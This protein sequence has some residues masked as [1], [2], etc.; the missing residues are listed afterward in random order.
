MDGSL[1]GCTL[2]IVD[3]F[4]ERPLAGNPLAVVTVSTMP[5]A[6]LRQAFARETNLSETTF[7]AT[8]PDASGHWPVKIHTPDYELPFAGHPTLGTAWVVRERLA[9]AAGNRAAAADA[10]ADADGEHTEVVL[11]LGVGPVRVRFDGAGAGALGWLDAPPVT[12][13]AAPAANDIAALLGVDPAV[14]DAALLPAALADTG[15]R[16]LITGL[17]SRDELAQLRPDAGA[18]SAFLR[19]RSGTGIL[20]V[21]S[22]AP[23]EGDFAARMFFDAGGVREDPAT[24][25][26][27]CC[28]AMVLR[29]MGRRG[30]VVLT[31][32]VEMQRPSRIRMQID[33]AAT[34]IGG[35]VFPVCSGTLGAVDPQD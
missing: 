14:I 11:A 7:V 13:D 4:A 9:G 34:C 24:G 15:P 6:E 31:Q 10:A 20:A 30:T 3:V 26:A 35:R 23:G 17:R 16:F 28:L 5:S 33:E 25:S 32:G 21:A 2:E 12:L 19:E 1:N 8:T 29:Q 18:L 27:A 22:A